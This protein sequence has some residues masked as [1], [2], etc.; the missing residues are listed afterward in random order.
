[1]NIDFPSDSPQVEIRNM[2][3][4]G[5]EYKDTQ[6]DWYSAREVVF[7]FEPLPLIKA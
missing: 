7:K 3:A 6:D 5:L 1:V 2:S 4:I